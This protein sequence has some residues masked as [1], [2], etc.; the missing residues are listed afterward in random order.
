MISSVPTNLD[1][2]FCHQNIC[3]LRVRM[4][5]RAYA[6]RTCKQPCACA[7]TYAYACVVCVNQPLGPSP[8]PLPSR[9]PVQYPPLHPDTLCW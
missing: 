6:Y 2:K 5:P 1:L 3:S 9:F 7:C 4:S 8:L